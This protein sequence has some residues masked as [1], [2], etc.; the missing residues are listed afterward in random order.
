VSPGVQLSYHFYRKS[1]RFDFET[2]KLLVSEHQTYFFGEVDDAS[3]I[4]FDRSQ[5]CA[6]VMLEM[7]H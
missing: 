5:T 4:D 6:E 2:G 7:R 3:S 1:L